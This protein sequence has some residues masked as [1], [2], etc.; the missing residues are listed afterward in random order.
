MSEGGG[1]LDLRVARPT[2]KCQDASPESKRCCS[3]PLPP[4]DDSPSTVESWGF[5][6]SV[7][8]GPILVSHGRVEHRGKEVR[9]GE[10]RL[11]EARRGEARRANGRCGEPSGAR[12]EPLIHWHDDSTWHKRHVRAPPTETHERVCVHGV[13]YAQIARRAKRT[14]GYLDDIDA[15]LHDRQ[16][17]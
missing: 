11:G 2:W 4:P 10:A 1:R 16:R 14:Q 7:V 17:K 8:I 12:G 5:R 6:R 3:S 15:G 13:Y 9:Q